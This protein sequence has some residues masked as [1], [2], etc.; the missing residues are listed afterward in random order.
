MSDVGSPR[1]VLIY[2]SC[3]SR[4]TFGFLTSDHELLGYTA[5]QS[6]ISVGAPAAGVAERLAPLASAFQDR[7]VR[8]DI[9]G[10]LLSTLDAKAASTDLLLLDLVDERGGVVRIGG[11]YVS[12]LAEF[13]SS[14]GREIA[15]GCVHVPFGDD[16]HFA[17]WAPAVDRVLDHVG[18]LG[19]L[20]RVVVLATPWADRLDDGTPLEV[21]GWMTPPR[22]ANA[23]YERYF[24]H[25]DGRDG[26]RLL[27]LPSD[28]ARSSLDHRW[29]PSPFHYQ[30]QAYEWLADR[31]RDES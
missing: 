17:L 11:G 16:E 4:D 21:P 20:G 28:L 1:R 18:E 6:A 27:R 14:G 10:N 22:V 30:D 7:M 26:I 23:Q 9:A 2:G 24:D 13:W 15:R 3:V 8:G 25:L 29:G 19:L 31:V 12:R 5:R